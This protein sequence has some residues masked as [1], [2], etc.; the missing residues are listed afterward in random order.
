[1]ISIKQ[2]TWAL[3]YLFL[4]RSG[5]KKAEYLKKIKAFHRMGENCYWHPNSIPAEPHLLSLGNNVFVASGVSFITHNMINCVIKNEAG[6]HNI[7]VLPFCGTISIGDNVFIGA[8]AMIMHGVKIG[9]NCVVAAGAVV[10]KDVESGS[11]VGGVPARPIGFYSDLKNKIIAFSEEFN[12]M[13][14]G[15]EG[16]LWE[17]QS[18]ILWG[19][20]K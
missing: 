15:T 7:N 14:V 12:S 17:K 3:L 8:R 10:T 16:T 4:H 19:K 18:V 5:W 20:E 1:M 2:R 9:D 6:G 13:C 11:V